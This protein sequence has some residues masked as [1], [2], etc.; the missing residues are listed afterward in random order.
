MPSRGLDIAKRQL[1]RSIHRQSRN[2]M[3][4]GARSSH[5]NADYCE[6]LSTSPPT[7]PRSALL[8][9][10]SS[11]RA[12]NQRPPLFPP[13]I[14]SISAV[15]HAS[16]WSSWLGLGKSEEAPVVSQTPT[17][18]AP[19][20]VTQQPP[21]PSTENVAAAAPSNAPPTAPP[22]APAAEQAQS[23]NVD[24]I[25][26]DNIDLNSAALD[27]AQIPEG[28]GYLKQIGVHF[29]LGPTSMLE[30]LLEH[31]H[32][33]GG[34]P[35]WAAIAAT[36]I[37]VRCC[38]F[39]FFLRMSDMQARTQA[40]SSVTKPFQDRMMQASNEGR[41]QDMMVAFQQM[42]AIR[43]RAGITTAGQFVPLGFQ[44]V[45]GYAGFKLMR[46]CA[47]LP[48]PGFTDGGFLW[49]KD[50]TMTDGYLLMPLFMAATMHM[51]I[52]VGGEAGAAAQMSPGMRNIMLYAMPAVMFLFMIW[53][54]GA[55]CVWFA[56]TG[57][58]GILQGRLLQRPA[59]RSYFGLAPLYKPEPGEKGSSLFD[60][61]LERAGLSSSKEVSSKA[62][63]VQGQSQSATKNAAYMQ[64]TYQSPNLR[65]KVVGN[66]ID[67]TIVTPNPSGT[68]ATSSEMIQ[69]G[70]LVE[71]E[72]MF[73]NLK[74]QLQ[75][76][77]SK[78]QRMRTMTPEQ[79]K[80]QQREAFKRKAENYEKNAQKR[81][82]R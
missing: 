41:T 37:L 39:P 43:K 11:L 13:P 4:S 6:Q 34:L 29:G 49:L 75:N 74:Q 15:R 80:K 1:S 57:A 66:K 54:P 2:V 20:A 46:T 56:S 60:S 48:V 55:V 28:I 22:T 67:T 35:W 44:A 45:I 42:A 26:F 70:A 12:S 8:R 31:F 77:V 19:A 62:S 76:T 72:S 58:V 78:F 69:P 65:R 25:T 40:L 7:L 68:T 5:T 79:V 9:P 10:T 27:A 33:W 63:F 53:Q 50:L 3:R 38:M 61:Y 18:T 24:T 30:W 71:K 16:S 59:V 14:A 82:R 21:P 32:I 52:R 81:G 51:V 36:G 23:F 47:E 73:G 64:P 17:P